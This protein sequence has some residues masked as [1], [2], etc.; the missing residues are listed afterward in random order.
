V[1]FAHYFVIMRKNRHFACVFFL[2]NMKIIVIIEKIEKTMFAKDLKFAPVSSLTFQ[3]MPG[4]FMSSTLQKCKLFDFF[5][6][7]FEVI[8]SKS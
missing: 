7:F 2:K 8:H 6:K 4:R 5:C 1:N 3:G